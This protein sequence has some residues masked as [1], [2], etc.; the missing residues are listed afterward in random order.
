MK[1]W[2]VCIFICLGVVFFSCN[3][4]NISQ[5]ENTTDKVVFD[6]TGYYLIDDSLK[7]GGYKFDNLSILTKVHENNDKSAIIDRVFIQLLKVGTDSL[8]RLEFK[9]YVINRD[10]LE[11]KITDTALGKISLI[12]KFM[13]KNGPIIDD[14]DSKTVVL[15][16]KL[17]VN[18]EFEKDLDFTWFGGD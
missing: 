9:D 18:N 17:K 5:N 4:N 12:G 11:L 2:K 14:V 10:R 13:T 16:A 3:S 6:P 15:K 8:K 7:I 1:I